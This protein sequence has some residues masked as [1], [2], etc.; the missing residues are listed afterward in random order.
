MDDIDNLN[1]CLRYCQ[2]EVKALEATRAELLHNL[3]DLRRR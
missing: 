2:R 3:T 1:A